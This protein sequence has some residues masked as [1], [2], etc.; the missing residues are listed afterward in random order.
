MARD[1]DRQTV[2]MGVVVE[3]V[4]SGHPELLQLVAA[5]EAEVMRRY[6]VD[7]AG[8]G[9][10][11]EAACL[12]A[13]LD[14]RAVGCVAVAPLAAR[15]GEVKRMYVEPAARG[16][17]VGA[18]LLRRA[19]DLATGLG[20][21]R[22]RLETGTEQPEAVGLYRAHGWAVIPCYGYFKDDPTTICMEKGLA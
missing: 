8:P 19:E 5:Q 20:Y 14:G 16:H 11:A 18:L 17:G 10:S 2:R 3:E 21:D 22:L 4:G 9:L 7:D 12:V 13:R 15:T 6:G 1:G